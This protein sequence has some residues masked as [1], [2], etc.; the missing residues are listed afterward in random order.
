[1]QGD[2]GRELERYLRRGQRYGLDRED[3]RQEYQLGLAEKGHKEGIRRVRRKID[4]ARRAAR[5]AARGRGGMEGS[6][7][8]PSA[9][10]GETYHIDP[11]KELVQVV[12]GQVDA[13]TRNVVAL[14]YGLDRGGKGR[15]VLETASLVGIS[16]DDVRKRLDQFGDTLRFVAS[17][18]GEEN[19]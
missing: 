3:M 2:D 14:Y 6:A 19:P 10:Q 9:A 1:M 13:V 4:A 11:Q 17:I 18:G 12:L 16:R 8:L 7:A 15:G 5:R